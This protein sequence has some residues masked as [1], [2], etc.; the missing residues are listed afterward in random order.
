[1]VSSPLLL[2]TVDSI[3]NLYQRTV[4]EAASRQHLR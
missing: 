1:M 4:R 3:S 2:L